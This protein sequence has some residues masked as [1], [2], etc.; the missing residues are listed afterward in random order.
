MDSLLPEGS[1][2]GWMVI[3]GSLRCLCDFQGINIFFKPLTLK[4]RR[5]QT[6]EKTD[7][8]VGR[9][10]VKRDLSVK[11]KLLMVDLYSYPH[12]WVYIFS[13]HFISYT[14]LVSS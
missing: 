12:P 4:S 8:W 9:I 10:G 1:T 3:T 7:W 11:A 5:Q 6:D 14:L 13:G 2:P